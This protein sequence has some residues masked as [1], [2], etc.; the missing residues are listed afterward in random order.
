MSSYV[1]GWCRI[2]G[3]ENQ[4]P[5]LQIKKERLC[6]IHKSADSEATRVHRSECFG[7]RSL[8]RGGGICS[9]TGRTTRSVWAI[10]GLTSDYVDLE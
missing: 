3:S 8:V 5:D 4:P 9:S 1:T 7:S 6:H 10:I 2:V